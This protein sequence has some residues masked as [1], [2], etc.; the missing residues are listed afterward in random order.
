MRKCLIIVLAISS[1]P[2]LVTPASGQSANDR[3]NNRPW[4]QRILPRA[5][6]VNNPTGAPE[7]TAAPTP[8]RLPQAPQVRCDPSVNRC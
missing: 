1:M 8:P 5:R 3:N 2:A 4:Y 7:R 6:Q